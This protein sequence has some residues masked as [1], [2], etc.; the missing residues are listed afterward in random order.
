MSDW[1]GRL[2]RLAEGVEGH[3]DAALGD[4]IRGLGV[5]GPARV[6]FFRTFGTD[7][8]IMVRGRVLRDRLH[9]PAGES[10]VRWRNL[11]A[12]VG[13]FES[14]EVPGARVR[15]RYCGT[16]VEVVAD[17]EGYFAVTIE[18][19]APAEGSLEWRQV[20]GELLSPPGVAGR[21]HVLVPHAGARF[22]VISDLDDTVIRTGVRNVVRMLAATFLENARTRLPFPG[23]AAFYHALRASGS[24][25]ATNPI[26]YV[27]SSPWNLHDYLLEFLQVRGI[28]VGPVMLRDWGT[29]RGS[30]LPPG[31]RVHKGDAIERIFRTYPSLPFVLI[32]DSGQR[33]PEIYREMAMRHPGRVLAAYIRDVTADPF[34]AAQVSRLAAEIGDLGTTMLLVDDTL[35]AAVHAAEHGW[36]AHDRVEAV[37]RDA[38]EGRS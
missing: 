28:P 36:I 16:E 29:S 35:A 20:E 33:D 7:E 19:S 10:D 12:A 11:L 24:G 21:G 1:W 26:F 14:D 37:A 25:E 23:V 3:V 18:G 2:A 5:V 27:S 9:A 38:V 32:G 34:R 4:R 13:R 8:R 6:C 22:G 30:L 15:A 31:H 17:I